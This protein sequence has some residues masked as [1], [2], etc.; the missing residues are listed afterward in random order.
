MIELN[1]LCLLLWVV[2]LVLTQNNSRMSYRTT[3]ISDFIH[4]SK[5][6]QIGF[7]GLAVGLWAYSCLFDNWAAW[8]YLFGAIGALGV[9]ATRSI[10]YAV[11]WPHQVCA[12]TAYGCTG[13]ACLLV[14]YHTAPYLFG[15]ALGLPVVGAYLYRLRASVAY[16]E[17]IIGLLL[18]LWFGISDVAHW[19]G[20]SAWTV[21]N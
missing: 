12:G 7:V 5:M 1:F 15:F 16:D 4:G 8:L 9:V 20:W 19:A 3:P 2:S 11:G 14:S 6:L 10:W 21:V 17:R 18:I 13:A